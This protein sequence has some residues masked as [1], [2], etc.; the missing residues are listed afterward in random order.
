VS[1]ITLR[2]RWCD[3]IVLNVHAATEDK[4]DD[5]KDNCYEE[6]ERIFYKFPKYHMKILLE[7]FN[8]R[9]RKEDI[10][11]PTTANESIHR[12]SND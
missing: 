7:D 4:I 10:F 11:K 12:I 2:G 6:L 9:V 3:I 5:M 8:A 1:Y